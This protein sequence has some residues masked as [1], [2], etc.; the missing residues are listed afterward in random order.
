MLPLPNEPANDLRV[1]TL[2][3][4]VAQIHDTLGVL[5]EY[6]FRSGLWHGPFFEVLTQQ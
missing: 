3:F 4:K 1:Q 6:M 2:N 5:S